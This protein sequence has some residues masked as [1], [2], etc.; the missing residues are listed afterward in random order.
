MADLPI[1]SVKLD[2]RGGGTRITK[3]QRKSFAGT[4]AEMQYAIIVACDEL[5]KQGQ[6]ISSKEYLATAESAPTQDQAAPISHHANAGRL[7]ASLVQPSSVQ[8]SQ[9]FKI[10]NEN[11]HLGVILVI[12]YITYNFYIKVCNF[13]SAFSTYCSFFGGIGDP[14]T[15]PRSAHVQNQVRKDL[16]SLVLSASAPR[17]ACPSPLS[18][19]P[20]TNLNASEPAQPPAP[21]AV[22]S[23][24]PAQGQPAS[25]PKRQPQRRPSAVVAASGQK[26]KRIVGWQ[27]QGS[28]HPG[29]WH[30]DAADRTGSAAALP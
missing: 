18:P 27:G 23:A 9:D 3:V 22:Q 19:T 8:A 26:T 28:W 7:T 16:G 24:E 30:A 5:L 20:S 13:L 1:K 17:S 11:E 6:G 2:R 4:G 10:E 14:A 29:P 21:A 15:D 12:M 25:N